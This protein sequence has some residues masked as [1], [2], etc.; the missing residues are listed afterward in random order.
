MKTLKIYRIGIAALMF[1][2]F[3]VSCSSDDD[4]GNDNKKKTFSVSLDGE[5]YAGTS[6]LVTVPS[7]GAEYELA[8]TTDEEVTWEI[9]I[10]EDTP[11]GFLSVS[12]TQGKGEATVQITASKKAE[13][14]T[15]RKGEISIKNST[16]KAVIVYSLQQ[17]DKQVV[18][19]EGT[20]NQTT[21]DFQDKNSKF[22]VHYMAEG[23]NVAIMYEK[24]WGENP[25]ND[26]NLPLDR[27][28]AVEYAEDIY[29][30]L[31]DKAGFAN[32]TTSE[33]SKYKMLIF[34]HHSNEGGAVGYGKPN[35]GILEVKQPG[36]MKVN[37][38]GVPGLLQ[39][40]MM[41]CFQYI[42]H[43]DGAYNYG[44]SGPIY[45]MTSQWG[46]LHRWPDWPDLEYGH[47]KDFMKNTH[48]AFM[49]EDNQ[50]HSPYVLEYWESIH[51]KMVSKL[52]QN[53]IEDD[54]RDP[55]QTYKR[56]N[57][58]TQ[59]QFNNEMFEGVCR[60]VTWDIPSMKEANIKH[61]DKHQYSLIEVGAGKK[62]YRA[63][64]KTCPQNYGY[65]CIKLKTPKAGTSV[66]I[67]FKGELSMSGYKI[68]ER[69]YAGWRCGFVALKENGERIYGEMNKE[70][71]KTLSFTVPE[72]GVKNLWFVVMG[73][74]TEHWK[75][76]QS[77]KDES[78]KVTE[79]NENN[80]PYTITIN[81]TTLDK[82]AEL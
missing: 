8:I 65:N 81:G 63:D 15:S 17:S 43:Y 27:K 71:E 4:E 72:S 24:S 58:L 50:Y 12:P 7:T 30:W 79:D 19:P 18:F 80:W 52:W 77:K 55:V 38:Y 67:D 74:P 41:H 32:W 44:W 31:I 51:P 23:P 28:K 82:P 66:T 6:Q 45:E 20:V 5:K 34:V 14:V 26:P 64:P 53:N 49:H 16:N 11:E 22:N 1:G 25:E 39:H 62:T 3:S 2:L 69:Q 13:N 42:S 40:E 59:E 10:S 46:L 33:A 56:L 54:E 9:A 61:I 73:A 36:I 70:K 21:A 76:K 75:H 47:F 60:F 57:N 78:G 68:K 35:V 48:K 37:K 29:A